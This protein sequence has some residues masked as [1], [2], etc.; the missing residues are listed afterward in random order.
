MKR[1]IKEHLSLLLASL[2]LIATISLGILA[3]A[4][5][6]VELSAENFPDNNFRNAVA[7]MYDT[8][9]DGYLS[10][11]ERSTESMIVSGIIE[12]YAFEND[13]DE[14]SLTV[15]D[16]TGIEYFYN[17]KSLRC[18]SIGTIESLDISELDKLESLACNRSEERRVGKECYQPCRSRW[19]PY[20]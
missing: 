16:L 4:E 14:D 8:N 9:G 2:L 19:S 15:N 10:R 3:F 20:H 17:L 7:L 11:S 5:D 13:L 1:F 6:E 12:M 18:S